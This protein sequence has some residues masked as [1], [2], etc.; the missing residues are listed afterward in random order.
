[1]Y[2]YGLAAVFNISANL[3]FIGRYSYIGA[4]WVTAATE[5]LVSLGM[6]LIIY[7]TMR[8]L[9]GLSV[10]AKALAASLL[11]TALLYASPSQNLFALLALGAASYAVFM[12][13]LG[14]ITKEDFLTLIRREF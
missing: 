10:L 7:K 4:A 1:M 13:I 8:Y 12:Y 3:Y 9:P 11:M 14:G 5:L 6:F 2:V